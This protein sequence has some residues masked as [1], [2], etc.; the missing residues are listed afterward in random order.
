MPQ[1][2]GHL[3]MAICHW[4]RP[5]NGWSPSPQAGSLSSP[6]LALED[7][8]FLQNH[9]G[10]LGNAGSAI[11]VGICS[12]EARGGPSKQQGGRGEIL[13]TKPFS[14]GEDASCPQVVI[15]PALIYYNKDSS[16]SEASSAGDSVCGKFTLEPM[17]EHLHQVNLDLCLHTRLFS[18][19]K[20]GL[21]PR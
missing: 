10:K 21:S 12:S 6:S 1:S 5:N 17:H 14:P 7:R 2:P 13:P 4:G 3:T 16:S 8:S 15:F 18:L 19:S 9:D 11:N 20:K